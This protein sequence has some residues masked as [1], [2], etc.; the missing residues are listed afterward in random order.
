M[1]LQ[2]LSQQN[3]SL[4]SNKV[5]ISNSNYTLMRLICV[6]FDLAL[7]LKFKFPLNFKFVKKLNKIIIRRMWILNA[8]EWNTLFQMWQKWAKY[9]ILGQLIKMNSILNDMYSIFGQL[10]VFAQKNCEYW[11]NAWNISW[12]YIYKSSQ[13]I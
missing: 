11:S 10:K 6:W 5:Y 12:I 3:Q 7:N 2:I 8:S 13:N 9:S 1:K 4:F